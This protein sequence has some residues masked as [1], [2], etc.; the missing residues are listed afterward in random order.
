MGRIFSPEGE[1]QDTLILIANLAVISLLTAFTLFPFITAGA[2]MA[3][4]YGAAATAR[5]AGTRQTVAAFGRA[6]KAGL[7]RATLWWLGCL[8]LMCLGVIELFWL[9]DSGGALADAMIALL[10][11]A[12]IIILG[13]TYWAIWGL[14]QESRPLRQLAPWAVV[15]FFRYLPRSLAAIAIASL[16]WVAWAFGPVWGGRAAGISLVFGLGLIAY[17][18]HA[19]FHSVEG[20]SADP[21]AA[22]L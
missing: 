5:D 2:A 6:F 14:V 19:L 3:G 11:S 1:L 7:G 18:H 10:L 15:C 21:S 22:Q 16:P 20:E 12:G 13:I 4:A 17:T 8:A 9:G